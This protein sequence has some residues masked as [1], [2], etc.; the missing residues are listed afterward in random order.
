M[1]ADNH[2]RRGLDARLGP[3]IKSGEGTTSGGGSR[4]TR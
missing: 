2:R 1:S 4:L 3:W